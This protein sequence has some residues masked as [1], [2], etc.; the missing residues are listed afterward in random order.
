MANSKPEQKG[1]L[2]EEKKAQDVID[3]ADLKIKELNAQVKDL[4]NTLKR[5]QADFENYKKRVER[6]NVAFIKHAH[7]ELI[8]QLLPIL[9][10]FELAFKSEQSAE[11]FRKG[12]ELVYAQ[13]HELFK[14]KGVQPIETKGKKFDPHLHVAL[15]QGYDPSKE[16]GS[17]LEELQRGYLLGDKVLQHSK[18]TVNKKPMEDTHGKNKQ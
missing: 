15:L 2:V 9:D 4:T 1:E 8:K 3:T 10:T 16:E 18:I 13:F 17:I 6:E 5:V 12:V 14:E 7:Q 11:D